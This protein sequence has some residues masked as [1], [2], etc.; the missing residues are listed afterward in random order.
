M[1][2]EIKSA[3]SKWLNSLQNTLNGST[4]NQ[5]ANTTQWVASYETPSLRQFADDFNS[6]QTTTREQKRQ[7][8]YDEDM[9]IMKNLND[10]KL[11]TKDHYVASENNK[12]IKKTQVAYWIKEFYNTNY[13]KELEDAWIDFS[14]MTN[15]EV[16]DWYTE[17]NPNSYNVLKSYVLTDTDINNPLEL[18]SYMW[19][20]PTQTEEDMAMNFDGF[21]RFIQGTSEN[22]A[23]WIN[24]TYQWF[25]NF[26]NGIQ[27]MFDNEAE[28]FW[29]FENFAYDVLW[30]DVD[31]LSNIEIYWITEALKNKEIY[32][33]FKPTPRKATTKSAAWISD[34]MFTVFLPWVKFAISAL[35]ADPLT[36]PVMNAVWKS[37]SSIWETINWL[38]P[39][40]RAYRSQLTDT[41][42]EEFDAFVWSLATMRLVG[43]Y[44]G[45]VK[46]YSKDIYKDIIDKMWP[47]NIISSFENKIK[48]TNLRPVKPEEIMWENWTD[49]SKLWDSKLWLPWEKWL[50][51]TK[52][53]EDM[54]NQAAKI[55]A[56]TRAYEN[57]KVSDALSQIWEAQLRNIKTYPE[58]Y[59][60]IRD[61]IS[62]LWK[63]QDSILDTFERT[64]TEENGKVW[65]TIDFGNWV[66][67]E[68]YDMP[69]ND[70]IDFMKEIWW[71]WKTRS[72]TQAI[73]QYY[74]DGKLTTSHIYKMKR[75]LNAVFRKFKKWIDSPEEMR[76]YTKRVTRISE[77]LTQIAREM[78]NKEPAFQQL[79]LDNVLAYTDELQS[80]NLYTRD[81]IWDLMNKINKYNADMPNS[82]I[83]KKT[84]T[85][86]WYML[87]VSSRP[88]WL[89]SR[90]KWP[91]KFTPVGRQQQLNQMLNRWSNLYKK[92][93]NANT[94]AEIEKVLDRF[95][96]EYEAEYGKVKE[97]PIEWEVID[98]A[99]WEK[100]DDMDA[101]QAL[102][103]IFE[104]VQSENIY[105]ESRM[106]NV[107]EKYNW[108]P[109]DYTTPTRVDPNGYAARYWQ[110]LEW[111]KTWLRNWGM[112]E[113]NID[114]F[115]DNIY[116][117]DNGYKRQ[118]D[119]LIRVVEEEWLI[120]NPDSQ[121]VVSAEETARIEE[122]KKKAI[123]K[124]KE[125]AKKK[126]EEKKKEK[127]SKK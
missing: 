73:E 20:L 61:N 55:W 31:S 67:T 105:P 91:E 19:W 108:N 69:I 17:L 121:T 7:Q 47:D 95:N 60:S 117:W 46:T 52:T 38:V 83:V 54:Y 18:Y 123:E 98:P 64:V 101:E 63:L 43:K 13:E 24:E 106:L 81:L 39:P 22:M 104:T 76:A 27:W 99:E 23:S 96:K 88:S 109:V 66:I 4:D 34:T 86:L 119:P 10:A 3:T 65:W 103:E 9:N 51:N 68:E 125:E 15:E 42:K 113:A 50:V 49:L 32:D 74:K 28:Y 1:R 92:L 79:W 85:L 124:A 11:N 118:Q 116:K 26:V 80:S 16:I 62:Y 45:K 48:P 72:I 5:W 58:L 126:K 115:V 122:M 89:A 127:D 82:T 94:P 6:Y 35:W 107:D 97:W 36:E 120:K 37:Q 77:Q 21:L 2:N 93:D 25:R 41:D 114:K 87:N 56:T 53:S 111:W 102:N 100:R 84:W 90:L 59:N 40:L 71:D 8:N 44:W 12:A 29:A 112:D 75:A 70:Y 57:K 33:E 110:T 14:N 30:K 78:I